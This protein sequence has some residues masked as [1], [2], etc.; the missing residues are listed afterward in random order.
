MT[1]WN[2]KTIA[3]WHEHLAD[4]MLSNPDR[5]LRE[6]AAIFNCTVNYIYMLKNSDS[7]QAYW[8]HRR[9]EHAAKLSDHVVEHTS[10]L[11]QKISAVAD[12][13]LDQI[14]SQLEKNDLAQAAG[15]PVI[16]HDELRSTADMALKK[17]GYGLPQAAPAVG[18]TQVNVTINSDLLA[19]ARER[20]K[21]LHG[22]TP[23]EPVEQLA[24]PAPRSG[25]EV[26]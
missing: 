3:W 2:P 15:A 18:G 16:P 12:M 1:K 10:G 7:F 5:D 24:L 11:S 23:A 26:E 22:V 4:W 17:L 14:L 8:Q 13:A 19:V 9:A 6:A 25:E 20:M 21:Q